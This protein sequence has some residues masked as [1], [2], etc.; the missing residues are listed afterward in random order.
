MA[1]TL[2]SKITLRHGAAAGVAIPRLGLGVYQAAEGEETFNSV[3]TALQLGYRHIDTAA[4]YGNEKSVGEALRASGIPRSEVF[5]TT[6][7]WNSDQGFAKTLAAF[8]QSRTKLGVDYVDLYLIHG[9]NT[10]SAKRLESWRALEQLLQ[11]G[12]C[13][14]IGVSNYGVRHLQ[15]LFANSTVKP[16]VNQ[17]ELSPFLN[18]TELVAFCKANEIVLEAYSP[19]TKGRKLKDPRLMAIAAKYG[20]TTAQILIRWGLQHDF[21]SLPKS[22]NPVRIRENIEIYDFAISD[23][24]MAALNAMEEGLVTG[25]DPTNAP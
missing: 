16:A 2:A 13:R 14:S 12:K 18:R 11:E 22:S 9:P 25:W 17:I 3:R 8:E 5:I 23:A 24:D 21:V 19:L 10:N 15:E 1:L 20:K 7:L 4:L 6:K